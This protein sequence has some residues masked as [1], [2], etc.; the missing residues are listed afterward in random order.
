MA[1]VRNDLTWG[2]TRQAPPQ[3]PSRDVHEWTVAVESEPVD[4]ALLG[5]ALARFAQDAAQRAPG[6]SPDATLTSGRFGLTLTIVAS[7][8]DEAAREGGR[9]FTGALETALWPHADRAAETRYEVR[10]VEPQQVS[11]AA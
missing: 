2:A 1:L 5:L 8:A 9:V 4:D 3:P 10:V 11:T 7:S 6:A